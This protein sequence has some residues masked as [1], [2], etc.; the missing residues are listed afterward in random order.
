MKLFQNFQ[1][2]RTLELNEQIEIIN[3]N[4]YLNQKWSKYAFY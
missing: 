4:F 2:R 3:F 1:K